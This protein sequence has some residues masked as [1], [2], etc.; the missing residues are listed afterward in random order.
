MSRLMATRLYALLFTALLTLSACIQ[1][2]TQESG[3][4]DTRPSITFQVSTSLDATVLVDGQAMGKVA[5]FQLG[6][7]QLRLVSGTHR[8]Q[9]MQGSSVLFDETVYLGDGVNKTLRVN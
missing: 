9:V 1:Y 4:V 3:S 8:V 2:P 7:A 5:D 6:T